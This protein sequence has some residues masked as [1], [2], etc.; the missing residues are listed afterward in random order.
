MLLLIAELNDNWIKAHLGFGPKR[1]FFQ[2][3]HFSHLWSSLHPSLSMYSKTVSAFCRK[4]V[5]AQLGQNSLSR[6]HKSVKSLLSLL[7]ELAQMF[8]RTQQLSRI[9][10][11]SSLDVHHWCRLS[12][13]S[14]FLYYLESAFCFNSFRSSHSH[15]AGRLYSWQITPLNSPS[16]VLASIMHH[17]FTLQYSLFGMPKTRLHHKVRSTKQCFPLTFAFVV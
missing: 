11:S 9:S 16:Q 8:T 7:S 12:N 5:H 1:I 13:R 14:F 15:F 2:I 10:R 6:A 17:A 3:S 4:S